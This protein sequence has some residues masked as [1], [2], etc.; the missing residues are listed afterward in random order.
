MDGAK[1]HVRTD[2]NQNTWKS[3]R[4]YDGKQVV[5]NSYESLSSH[6][7]HFH[8]FHSSVWLNEKNV[9]MLSSVFFSPFFHFFRSGLRWKII[10]SNFSPNLPCSHQRKE[11]EKINDPEDSVKNA[12]LPYIIAM[13]KKGM[14]N[15]KMIKCKKFTLLCYC[16]AAA[17]S[18]Y[19]LVIYFTKNVLEKKLMEKVWHF[20]LC[21][22]SFA[23][24]FK[25]KRCDFYLNFSSKRVALNIIR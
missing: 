5:T 7:I 22:L 16:F 10:C 19:Q 8:S 15:N 17:C 9:F 21:F 2:G 3:P 20:T 13:K 1:K 24:G 6:F 14:R 23:L 25:W 12:S 11:T 4:T 18:R